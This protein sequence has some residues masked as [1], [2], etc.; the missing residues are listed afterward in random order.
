MHSYVILC[1]ES[2]DFVC[3]LIAIIFNE[4]Y[5]VKN[6]CFGPRTWPR[7]IKRQQA[8]RVQGN[9]EVLVV[10]EQ[11][12]AQALMSYHMNTI[13]ISIQRQNEKIFNQIRIYSYIFQLLSLIWH[14]R[15]SSYNRKIEHILKCELVCT[16]LVMVL[17]NKVLYQQIV[18]NCYFDCFWVKFCAQKALFI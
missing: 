18:F 4:L 7:T 8:A 15:T 12:H 14:Y 5:V 9:Y 10:V 2:N 17:K 13:P 11:E 16:N 1:E 3:L 6:T